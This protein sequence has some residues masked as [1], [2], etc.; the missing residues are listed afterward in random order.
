MKI[1]KSQL[2]L[3]LMALTIISTVGIGSATLAASTSTSTKIDSKVLHLR[4]NKEIRPVLTEAQ[5]TAR[6]TK[7]AAIESALKASDY[8]AWVIA[9]G[10]NAPIL[11]KINATNFSTYVQIYTLKQQEQVL[12]T[13][14]GLTD[15]N[16]KGHG[17]GM[18]N[19]MGW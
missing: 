11:Q 7:K 3:G 10:P 1:K 13:Q 14:L 4:N 18:M 17:L 8:N 2:A 19:G 12:K 5:K 15:G 9:V 16:E 6:A